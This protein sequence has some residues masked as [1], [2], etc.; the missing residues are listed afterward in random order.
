MHI[1]SIEDDT[2]RLEALLEETSDKSSGEVETK[3]KKNEDEMF[4]G[5]VSVDVVKPSDGKLYRVV[6]L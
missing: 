4:L 3:K 1:A 6:G 2:S 5:N